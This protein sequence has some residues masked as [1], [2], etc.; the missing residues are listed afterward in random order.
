MGAGRKGGR[1]W[2]GRFGGEIMGHH[3]RGWRRVLVEGHVRMRM[4]RARQ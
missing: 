3:E 1:G 4:A 2:W